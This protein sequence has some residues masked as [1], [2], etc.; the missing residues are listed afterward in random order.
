MKEVYSEYVPRSITITKEKYHAIYPKAFTLYRIP[1][2]FGKVSKKVVVNDEI[3]EYLVK[4]YPDLRIVDIPEPVLPEI[5]KQ[6][7][8]DVK[9]PDRPRDG[10]PNNF[11]DETE[12]EEIL[13]DEEP[14][15]EKEKAG[16]KK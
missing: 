15:A 4:N 16:K 5:K 10:V 6:L 13:G 14:E 2:V 9:E 1:L 12:E 11:L 3:A 8:E 7:E